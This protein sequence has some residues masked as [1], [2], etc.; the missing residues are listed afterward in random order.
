M[1]CVCFQQQ[2]FHEDTQ[3]NL[4]C[5]FLLELALVIS[6]LT[7]YIVVSCGE[8]WFTRDKLSKAVFSSFEK[9]LY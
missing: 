5:H 8:L 7:E 9:V 6:L 4:L 3:T 2:L 1:L